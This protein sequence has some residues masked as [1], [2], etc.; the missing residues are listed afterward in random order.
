LS[1]ES[2]KRSFEQEKTRIKLLSHIYK[3]IL[4]LNLQPCL[5]NTF[6]VVVSIFL[7]PIFISGD[8]PPSVIGPGPNPVG[9]LKITCR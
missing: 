2:Q 6:I 1:E 8:P 5:E 7:Q 4:L 9:P 3:P